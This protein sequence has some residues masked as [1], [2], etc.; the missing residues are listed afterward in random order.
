MINNKYLQQIT[1]KIK[2]FSKN[3]DIQVFIFG[4]ALKKNAIGDVD[5]GILGKIDKKNLRQLKEDFENSN[6]PF[7]VDVVNFNTVS[8]EFKENVFNSKIK[9]IKQ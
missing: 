2:D 4:S 8:K 1:D 6:L 3:R 7:F 5:I 9:W